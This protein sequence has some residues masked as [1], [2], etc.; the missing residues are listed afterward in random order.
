MRH[1]ILLSFAAVISGAPQEPD[2]VIN[3]ARRLH[4]SGDLETARRLLDNLIRDVKSKPH[5]LPRAYAD[6]GV[7]CHDQGLWK[8][9]VHW[10]LKAR[11][12]VAPNSS[13]HMQIL[14]NLTSVYL[15]SGQYG[16]AERLM[17]EMK[18]GQ[19]PEGELGARMKGSIASLNMARGNNS[20]A[21]EVFLELVVYW[22]KAG[23]N[24]EVA[25]ILNN[26]GVLALDRKDVETSLAHLRR[27][28]ELWKQELGRDHV[29]YVQTMANYGGALL[30][31]G[32]TAEAEEVL[33]KA[34]A[35]TEKFHGPDSRLTLQISAIYAEA[36]KANG[37]KKEAKVVR[38]R[39]EQAGS[40]LVPQTV[41]VL[42]LKYRRR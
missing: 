11:K 13:L 25:V 31:A 10:H 30:T 42:D 24:R 26:L 32:Q 5:W 22:E 14:N 36:L 38:Q 12:I 3:E 27:A 33:A 35:I 9:A 2:E 6:L 37:H 41:D 20:V 17:D 28:M 40:S 18:K 34:L 8:D 7:V 21:E 15:E 39:V 19:W 23:K 16:K 1:L 29:M 4:N